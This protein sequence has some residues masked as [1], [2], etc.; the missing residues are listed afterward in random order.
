[1]CSSCFFVFPNPF[2]SRFMCC[3]SL[4]MYISS[5]S[6]LLRSLLLCSVHLYV[7]TLLPFPI[8][9]FF[10]QLKRSSRPR[11]L[12]CT[13]QQPPWIHHPRN[14]QEKELKEYIQIKQKIKKKSKYKQQIVATCSH[15]IEATCRDI[16]PSA[17]LL[18]KVAPVHSRAPIFS[19]W[20]RV[21]D[22]PRWSM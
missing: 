5:I 17:G 2:S 20:S 9:E 8:Q 1:M 19:S 7:L 18:M 10:L 16:N 14:L 11:C 21:H 4:V 3:S 6:S 13:M 12:W 15:C 22:L